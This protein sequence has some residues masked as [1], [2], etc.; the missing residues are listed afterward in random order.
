MENV[1]PP[2]ARFFHTTTPPLPWA[3]G[4]HSL[5][6]LD[7]DLCVLRK[8][9]A[10]TIPVMARSRAGAEHPSPH[11]AQEG[12]ERTSILH[13]TKRRLRA[14]NKYLSEVTQ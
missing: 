3:P 14:P 6:N 10:V 13:M 9:K 7:P 1:P 11:L 2:R 8:A 4:G 5:G 12:A